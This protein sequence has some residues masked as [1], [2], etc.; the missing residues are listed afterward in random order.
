LTVG[1][2]RGD[3]GLT[4]HCNDDPIEIAGPS[5]QK[6]CHARKY[7]EH[8]QTWFGVC[9]RPSDQ[10]LR[11]GLNLEFAWEQNDAMDALTKTL[12]GPGTLTSLLKGPGMKLPK[13]GRNDPCP[14]G[15]GKKFKKCCIA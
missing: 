2:G 14:C 11:F 7:T 12:A 5:L 10:T 13:I 8:A 1:L 9:M 3:T 6:H 4:I 15:S